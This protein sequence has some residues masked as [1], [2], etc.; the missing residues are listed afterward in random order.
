M[1]LSNFEN[2]EFKLNDKENYDFKKLI[3]SFSPTGTSNVLLNAILN[4]NPPKGKL[5]DLGSGIGI[6]GIMLFL[7]EIV[8]RLY[9]VI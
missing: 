4:Y 2:F 6:I 7:K 1:Q 5:L 9:T 8:P 3:N